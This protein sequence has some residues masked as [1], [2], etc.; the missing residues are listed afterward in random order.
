MPQ[1]AP[2]IRENP[3]WMASTLQGEEAQ[4]A[5]LE[6]DYS[7]SG[8]LAFSPSLAALL[9][10][11]IQDVSPWEFAHR[12]AA[13]HWQTHY[14][15]QPHASHL[16]TVQGKIEAFHHFCEIPDWQAAIRLF[17]MPL[18]PHNKPLHDQLGHW[19]YYQEQIELYHCL[20]QG[21]LQGEIDLELQGLCWHGLGQ[22][23]CYLGR[24]EQAIAHYQQALAIARQHAQKEL[25]ARVLGGL[26]KVYSY[27]EKPQISREFYEQQRQRAIAIGCLE[28]E[29]WALCGLSSCYG[30]SGKYRQSLKVGQQ[31]LAIAQQLQ[32]EEIQNRALIEISGSYLQMGNVKQAIFYLREIQLLQEAANPY[33]KWLMLHYLGTG[34][35]MLGQY[36]EGE[37]YLHQ[38]L[39]NRHRMKPYQVACTTANL[40][41][42]YARAG[43]YSESLK[44][45]QESYKI[46]T[47]L[48]HQ[49]AQSNSLLNMVYAYL[50]LGEYSKALDGI[51]QAAERVQHSSH[52]ELHGCLFAARAALHWK[53][54]R[55]VRA[56]A[57]LARAI[58]IDPPWQSVNGKITLKIAIQEIMDTILQ[59]LQLKNANR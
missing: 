13:E 49:D 15:P 2:D 42:L 23:C 44:Y 6:I 30:T 33:Q 25:E 24:Y 29:A 3:D 35:M 5:A 9:Q 37:R 59:K 21:P 45:S 16:E 18:P 50:S 27:L 54:G 19:G 36:Q 51:N 40:A 46:Y 12:L 1:P 4:T 32:N 56:L 57:L 26:G 39:V 10:E 14:Q 28:Q 7:A 34:Y 22:A 41:A 38:V 55:Y 8:E 43:N 31:G 20:L 17:Q 58:Y 52:P 53:Q 48:G 11:S 47:A